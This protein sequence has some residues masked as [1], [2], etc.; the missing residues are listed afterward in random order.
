MTVAEMITILQGMP[1]DAA[2]LAYD[3]PEGGTL[4]TPT[5]ELIFGSAL[6]YDWC[7]VNISKKGTAP[8]VVIR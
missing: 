5:V 3:G 1:Q 4:Q 8:A 7:P 2:V 6:E